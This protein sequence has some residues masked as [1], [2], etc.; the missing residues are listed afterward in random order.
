M[1]GCPVQLV[2]CEV[3][4]FSWGILWRENVFFCGTYAVEP[5]LTATLVKRSPRYNG[6]T[7]SYKKPL[8]IPSP[9]NTANGHI[10]KSQI[11]K[12]FIISPC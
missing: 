11:V 10:L 6:H 12:S 3:R 5:H 2:F 1:K 4:C 9:V 7:F 8:L